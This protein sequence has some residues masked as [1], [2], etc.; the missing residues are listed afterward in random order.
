M[1]KLGVEGICLEIPNPI[2]LKIPLIHNCFLR[3][4]V[5]PYGSV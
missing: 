4:G 5:N 3:W 1:R 2:L